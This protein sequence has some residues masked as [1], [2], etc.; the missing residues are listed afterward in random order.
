VPANTLDLAASRDGKRIA[1]LTNTKLSYPKTG[2]VRAI[3]LFRSGYGLHLVR[4]FRSTAPLDIA[5]SPDGREIAYG[6]NSEIWVMRTDGSDDHQVTEGHSVAW[7]PAFTPDGGSLVFDRD[8]S[9]RPRNSPRIFRKP[10]AGGPEVQLTEDEARNPTVSSTGLLM[11]TRSGEGPVPSR[12][13][14]MRMDGGGRH[15]V[16]LFDDPFFDLGTT[17]SPDG[18]SIAFLRL[19]EKNGYAANYR[20]SLHTRSIGGGHHRKLVGGIRGSA[21]RVPFAGHGPAGPIWVP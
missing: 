14:V 21:R 16:D 13:I 2:S 9:M 6:K 15:T 1:L 8:A 7:D 19:W 12:V 3:Y 20:Y 10:L 5:I 17:F 4:R 18:R 11:Y